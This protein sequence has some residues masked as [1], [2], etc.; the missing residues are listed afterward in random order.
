MKE[1]I[2]SSLTYEFE[3]AEV[4]PEPASWVLTVTALAGV[5]LLSRRWSR[6]RTTGNE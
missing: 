5:G 6:S 4:I 3:P 1:F 2:V